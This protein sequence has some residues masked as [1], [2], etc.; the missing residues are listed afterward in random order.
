MP[1][2]INT[3]KSVLGRLAKVGATM[4]ADDMQFVKT[5]ARED[6]VDFAPQAGGYKPGD[7]IFINKPAR[8]T[9]G[10]NRDI[11]ST[12]QDINEEKVQMTLNQSF[13]SAVALT[14]NEFATE[15]AF[16]SF[17]IGRAHV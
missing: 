12:I 1:N 2:T 5:I 9:T 13:T 6:S 4:F 3:N 8:F 11:T 15:M 17:E 7:T 16:D 10:T 14:S